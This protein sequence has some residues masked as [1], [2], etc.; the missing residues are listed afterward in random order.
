VHQISWVND[1]VI[2]WLST[3]FFS[4]G[5]LSNRGRDRNEI[6]HKGSLGDDDDAQTS[7]TCIA[8]KK[9]AIPHSMMKNTHNIIQCCNNTH[10]GALHTDKQTWACASDLGASSHVTCYHCVCGV[11]VCVCLSVCLSVCLPFVCVCLSVCLF[12]CPVCA[13]TVESH[14]QETSFLVYTYII[15][16][17]RSHSWIKVG[18]GQRNRQS[19]YV[20]TVQ[21]VDYKLSV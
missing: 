1:W 8:Q 15:S 16:L 17:F 5:Q 10:Q 20:L 21:C 19:V 18:Q 14:N 3:Q 2:D 4:T 11:V 9:R 12:V 13:M 7:N 6:W